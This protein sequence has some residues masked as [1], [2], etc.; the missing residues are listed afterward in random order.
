MKL[1]NAI[2]NTVLREATVVAGRNAMDREITWV[3]IVDHPEITNWLKPGE[4]L[5]TT[6]YNWPVDDDICRAMVRRLS[7]IGLAGVVLAVPH[8]REHFTQAAIDEADACNLPL[9]ELPWEVPFSEI[10]HDVLA[11]IINVQA[12]IIRRSDLIHR[13]LTS[14]ALGSNNLEGLA[15][16]LTQALD[17]KAIVVAG[18][19]TVLGSSSAASDEAEERRL[20]SKLEHNGSLNTIFNTNAPVLFDQALDFPLSRLGGPVRLRGEVIGVIWLE[21]GAQAFE[22]LDVRALEHACVIA[23]LHLTHQRELSDQEVRLGYAFVAGLLE[24]KFSATPSAIERAQASGWSESRNYRVC[25]VLLN[26][27]IPLAMDGFNRRARTAERISQVLKDLNVA[28]LISVSLNQISFL[29]PVEISAEVIWRAIRGEGGAMAVSRVHQGVRGMALGAED[30]SALLPVL[31]P[32]KI[33]TFDE[34]LFP[35]ALMG[36][37]DA[38]RLLLAQMIEPLENPKR[39]N[40]L[41]DTA[42]ALSREGFQLLN[43]AKDLDIHIS[44]LRYRVERIESILHISLDNPQDRFKLQVA[45]QMYRLLDEER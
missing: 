34:V 44:T 1:A 11:R 36:D 30:V 6:G 37:A 28:P 31:R 5:L 16:A 2:D 20:M 22:E 38:R 12:E 43:T 9:L 23:A 40:S 33:H 27:P 41:I 13:T 24:G 35:R 8:F 14:A 4:L 45:A 10:T 21:R 3:H 17:K 39:G 15:I 25:L 42:L 19:G 7:E 18:N 29:L 32:G 26:E